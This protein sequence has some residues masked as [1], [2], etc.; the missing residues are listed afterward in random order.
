MSLIAKV[1]LPLFLM[2]VFWAAFR[3]LSGHSLA[4]LLTAAPAADTWKWPRRSPQ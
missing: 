4:E 2:A 1:A 3:L